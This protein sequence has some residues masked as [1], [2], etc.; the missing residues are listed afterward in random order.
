[1]RRKIKIDKFLI[2]NISKSGDSNNELLLGTF[3]QCR[4]DKTIFLQVRSNW[5]PFE[6]WKYEFVQTIL[7][8]DC[9]ELLKI[10][11]KRAL[12]VSRLSKLIWHDILYWPFE[13]GAMIYLFYGGIWI[14][15]FTVWFM[16]QDLFYRVFGF[17]EQKLQGEL[18]LVTGG[19]GGLGRLISLRLSKLGVDI[20]IWDIKQEGMHRA[21]YSNEIRNHM[22]LMPI[23]HNFLFFC[24]TIFCWRTTFFE[25]FH[26]KHT[27]RIIFQVTW[28]LFF[29]F[30]E[31]CPNKTLNPLNKTSNF[32]E[33]KF[34]YSI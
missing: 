10:Y 8:I 28:F 2:W 32:A 21:I 26:R 14:Q 29:I 34:E 17:P 20:V 15:N 31:I 25:F 19:G 7:A 30:N 16:L 22:F 6:C 24:N 18:A 33:K 5:I 23:D 11:S 3:M 12:E 4:K 1:M 9:I 27:F 13:I